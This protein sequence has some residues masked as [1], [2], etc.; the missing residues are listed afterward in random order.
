MEGTLDELP[1]RRKWR[2]LERR[3]L[4]LKMQYNNGNRGVTPA[5][6]VQFGSADK[7]AEVVIGDRGEVEVVSGG[8]PQ[9]MY[10]LYKKI[11]EINW[12]KT[13]GSFS[14]LYNYN[15]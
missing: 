9:N 3:L 2:H 13:G 10:I 12:D 5:V 4:R 1:P 15:T 6:T 14:K 8:A 7:G 11:N